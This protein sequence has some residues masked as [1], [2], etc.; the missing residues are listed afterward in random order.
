LNGILR[1]KSARL[2]EFAAPIDDRRYVAPRHDKILGHGHRGYQSEML[3]DHAQAERVGISGP[4]DRCFFILYQ[5]R[6][7]IG[8]IIPQQAFHQRRFAGAVLSQQP[9]HTGGTDF[10]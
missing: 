4:L 10:H 1:M 9:V 8:T 7:G 6:T 5:E 2:T 3:V